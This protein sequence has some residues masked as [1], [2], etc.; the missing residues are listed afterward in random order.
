MG[1]ENYGDAL[2]IALS[3]NGMSEDKRRDRM[4]DILVYIKKLE[5]TIDL[6]Q[7]EADGYLA[8]INKIRKAV[9]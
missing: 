9:K 7:V 2:S 1:I 8:T 6:M 5:N 4:S 3:I